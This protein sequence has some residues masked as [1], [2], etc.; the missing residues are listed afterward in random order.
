[1]WV[2]DT[3][4]DKIYAYNLNTKAR[5]S[6]GKDFTRSAGRATTDADRHLVQQRTTMWVAD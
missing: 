6:S 4:D 5:D 1:M 2:A 3:D